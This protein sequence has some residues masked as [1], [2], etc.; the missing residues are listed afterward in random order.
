VLRIA[1][2]ATLEELPSVLPRLTQELFSALTE[3]EL[4]LAGAP[5][6]EYRTRATETYPAELRL[7]APFEGMIRPPAG[8]EVVLDPAHTECFVGLEQAAAG[9]QA[10]VVAVH[11][12]LSF[13]HGRHRV[14][15]NQEIYH[16]GFGTGAPGV[17]M[18]LALPVRAS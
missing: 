10:L 7:C 18:D 8:M 4:P 3:A 16:P 5:Y 11:D 9:D 2:T 13:H 6:V 15:P 12:Y 14:G 1:G 17:V